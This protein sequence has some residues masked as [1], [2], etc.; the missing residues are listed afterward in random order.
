M[1]ETNNFRLRVRA[2]VSLQRTVTGPMTA[3]FTNAL[4]LS[5]P[6][7]EQVRDQLTRM[8]S[9]QNLELP[10]RGRKFLQFVVD[11]TL[12][13]RQGYIKAVTIAQLVFGRDASFDAQAD[14]CVR[15]EASRIRRELERYYLLQGSEDDIV[16]TV[17]K[18]AYVPTF[19]MRTMP[20]GQAISAPTKPLALPEDPIRKAGLEP[21]QWV[22]GAV[23][24]GSFVLVHG[25]VLMDSPSSAITTT[26]QSIAVEPF[27]PMSPDSDTVGIS[28]SFTYEVVSKL[29]P[30]KK[31]V[32]K[33]GRT[34]SSND[35]LY[36]LQG[37]VLLEG[38]RLRLATRLVRRSDGAVVWA[39]NYDDELDRKPSF[40]IQ[41]DI[42]EKIAKS[43]AR[44]LGIGKE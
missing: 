9:S 35:S 31:L 5:E 18:G 25:L 23:T 27:E 38:R 20:K 39:E 32:V 42:A 2:C 15:I 1:L 13:G 40:A 19:R 11:E 30:I 43:I 36:L 41:S 28:L 44:P 3:A 26:M 21:W 37:A 17:P 12:D 6:S 24:I 34:S 10:Q 29:V 16:I 22:V 33:A 14:P 4:Q 7:P 8:L